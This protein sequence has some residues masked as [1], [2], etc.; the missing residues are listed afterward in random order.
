VSDAPTA[1]DA[2]TRTAAAIATA[3]SLAAQHGLPVDEPTVLNDGVNVVVRPG[4]APVVARVAT[5]TRLLRPGTTTFRRDVELAGALAARGAPVVAPTDLMPPG[6]HEHGGTVVSFWTYVDVLP[7]R[8]TPG[9][10]AASFAELQD[11]LTDQPPTGR[12]LDTPLDD[13]AA[14]LDRADR[15][16]VDA[17]QLDVL[18]E[19]LDALRPHL[20]GERRQLHG[21]AYPGNLLATPQGWRWTDLEDSCSGPVLWDFA[22]L[23]ATSRLDGRAAL[24]ALPSAPSDEELAPFL[25]LRRLHGAAWAVVHA[26]GHPEFAED[27]HQY[28]AKVLAAER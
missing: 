3:V 10:A 13:L 19:R 6:P 2:R 14:F 12:P 16:G 1:P 27:A 26:Q 11:A 15:W 17:G 21:D 24:D 28:L 5:L 18:R 20:A 9:Q 25:A 23:R 7:E 4:R 22:C 8:P